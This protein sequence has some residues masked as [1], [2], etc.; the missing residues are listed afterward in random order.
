[1]I[2]RPTRAITS[3]RPAATRE[4]KAPSSLAFLLSQVGVY[5]ARRFA[6]RIAA[7]D[8]QP[9]LFRVLNVVDAAEGQSQQAIGE[10]IGAP[11]SRMVAIVDELEQRGLVERRPHPSDRRIRALYLTGEGRKLLARGR[12]IATEHGEELTRGMSAADR[13]RLI[14]L[15]QGVVEEQGIGGG[16]HPGFSDSL[17]R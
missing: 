8:L 6:Q 13:K 11:A 5:A 2:P 4:P 15:L 14:A 7:V 16:V 1:V 10:A 17:A 9:P 12:R 3:G